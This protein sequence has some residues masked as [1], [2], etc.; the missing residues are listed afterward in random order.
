MSDRS[1]QIEN[2]SPDQ[3][4]LLL[5]RLQRKRPGRELDRIER[6]AGGEAALPLSF[7]QQR[8][9][10]LDQLTPGTSAYNVP[11]ALRLRGRLDAAA[12]HLAFAEIVRRHETLRTTFPA[13]D[14][15]PR[16]VIAPTAQTP[17]PVIDLAGLPEERRRQEAGELLRS[18]ARRPFH[19]AAGPLLRLLLLR[20]E[21]DE[22]TLLV[23]VHHIVADGW[24][25]GVLVRELTALYGDL[26]AGRRPALLEL[27]VQYADFALWQRQK[28]SGERLEAELA[29]WRG[30]LAGAPAGLDLPA[31]R[32]RPALPSDRGATLPLS[33][34]ETAA[35]GVRALAQRH[36]AT[37]FMVLLAAFQTLLCRYTGRTDVT[38]GSPV[39][40]RDRAEV[41]GLIGFFIN[42]LPLR[43]DLSGD[44][45]FAALVDRVRESTL[46]A[47][48]HQELPFEKLAEELSAD[49]QPGHAPLF[50]TVFALQ[51]APAAALELSGL[52]L[53][54]LALED[55]TAKFDL[56]LVLAEREGGLAG[57]LSYST[58]LFERATV[59]RM[60]GHFGRL[61]TGAVETP[62]RRLSDLPLLAEAE[63][64]Q[65]V[66]WNATAA[67]YPAP[68]TGLHELFE[69][70]AERT[71][72][73]PAVVVDGKLAA[74]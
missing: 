68:G 49:R 50:Q 57:T 71:P 66:E 70:Q 16:Q 11:T 53:E 25:V 47:Y 48:A 18:E 26:A 31:D 58:D 64:R 23:C 14:G 73:A 28:L 72:G 34:P 5:R 41:Q 32:P 54:P 10:F 60:A 21:E 8:L 27:P 20:L 13:V 6:R 40:G 39:A 38:V 67:D 7:S 19:L 9:W 33:L 2:L 29:H 65:L 61:L 12:L 45:G 52:T 15:E 56:T 74:T 59:E 43:A 3:M 22:H 30:R 42:T 24:S 1:K 44:P 4:D 35:A 69:A 55:E 37:P 51:N 36:G 46:E 17:L 63:R 62:D